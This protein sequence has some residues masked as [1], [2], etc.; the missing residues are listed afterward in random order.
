MDTYYDFGP[1]PANPTRRGVEQ[2]ERLA[3]CFQ[4]ALG[5][6]LP[7]QLVNMQGLARLVLLEQG[8]RLD[9]EGRHHLER[10]ADL[11][12]RTGGLV[13]ALAEVGRLTRDPGPLEAVALPDATKEAAAELNLLSS[14]WSIQYD[15]MPDASVLAVSRR[16][17]RLALLHL[18]RN[19]VQADGGKVTPLE[20]GS[21]RTPEGVEWWVKDD[22]RGFSETQQGRLFDCFT[23]GGAGLGLFLVRQIVAGWGG[24][25]RV[26]SEPGRGTTITVLVRAP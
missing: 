21:R 20:V 2:F 19:A 4:K 12:Q 22:G 24:A 13:R 26:R 16:T 3:A 1:D 25:I 7:N 11:A 18:I 23:G 9:E 14:G 8:E 5:H 17:L 15:F 6:E 10:L